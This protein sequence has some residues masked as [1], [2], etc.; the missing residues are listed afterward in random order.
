[1]EFD[2]LICYFVFILENILSAIRRLGSLSFE[3]SNVL[4]IAPMY[5]SPWANRGPHVLPP[6]WSS[7]SGAILFRG[8]SGIILAMLLEQKLGL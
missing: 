7:V 1:M 8:P 3:S 4:Y 2:Y 6:P 5:S